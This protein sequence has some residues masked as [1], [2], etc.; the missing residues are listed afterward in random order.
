MMGR[1]SLVAHRGQP[2]TFPE[3]SLPGFVHAL[4]A[5]AGYVETDVHIT[6]DGI[7]VLSHD[8]N[9]LKLSGK[10]IIVADHDLALIQDVPLGYA[11][12]FG[13][14]YEDY[15]IAT[16]AQFVELMQSWPDARCFVELKAASLQNF[17]MKAVDL[18]L[19][20][21][22]PIHAQTILISFEYD[23]LSYAKAQ[24]SS[25]QLG[26]VL[27]AWNDENHQL[28]RDLAPQFLFVDDEFCPS[29][30]S[31]IW[32]GEWQ[33]AVYTINDSEQVGHYAGL[34]IEIIETDR[35]SELVEESDIVEV[36]N[37]F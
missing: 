9:L 22:A 11:E 19:E 27:P 8:A 31:D 3:N 36:S 1:V 33:W 25:L 17:G 29:E 32:P 4:E 16:L 5:G 6:A 2:Q 12:R 28:A 10:Q 21:I 34:G 7:P 18:V 14:R 20:Q 30:Q 15:R 13:G 35:Y 37:D 26:W 24:D 23:A